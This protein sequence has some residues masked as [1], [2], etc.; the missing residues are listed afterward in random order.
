VNERVLCHYLFARFTR[1]YWSLSADEQAALNREMLVDFSNSSDCLELY[2]VFPT[3]ADAEVLFWSTVTANGQDEAGRFF[4]QFSR[5]AGRVRKY[6]EPVQT[7]WGF[8]RPSEYARGKSSQEI[9]PFSNNRKP[10]LVVY[11]FV[12]TMEWYRLSR[13]ARQGMMNEHIRIGHQYPEIT[14]LLLYSTGLQDQE[15]V[16]VYETDDL[17]HFSKLVTDLRAT[18]A[19]HYTQRDTPIFTGVYHPAEVTLDIVSGR[20]AA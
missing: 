14:Q 12:K 2:Q 7:L 6:L 19:R 4:E 8:T 9:D 20:E 10:Y 16:V 17:A 18:E 15:F 1:E 3:R 13:D 5:S 11:P